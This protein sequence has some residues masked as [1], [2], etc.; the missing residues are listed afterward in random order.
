MKKLI[1]I[2]IT[3]CTVLILPP[4]SLSLAADFVTNPD[5]SLIY[6]NEN[7]EL[8][9]GF[10]K[11]KGYTYYFNRD[12]KMLTGAYFIG[13]AHYRFRDDGKMYIGWVKLA[14]GNY[15]YYLGDGKRAQG[16][17]KIGSATYYFRADG[18]M[19]RSSGYIIDNKIYTFGSDGKLIK[20]NGNYCLSGYFE[21]SFYELKSRKPSVINI[22]GEKTKSY[23]ADLIPVQYRLDSN[24]AIGMDLYIFVNDKLSGGL[25]SFSG[26]SKAVPSSVLSDDYGDL[27]KLAEE[28]IDVIFEMFYT[29]LEKKYGKERTDENTIAG[30]DNLFKDS[31]KIAVFSDKYTVAIVAVNDGVVSQL[32]LDKQ[33]ISTIN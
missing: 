16:F 7:G 26:T 24:Y 23:A 31:E 8:T 30:V 22:G 14:D 12:G 25:R 33:I 28:E 19:L 27:K 6:L 5:G 4:L 21:E 3:I 11:I 1:C 29:E 13:G 10:T 20:I 32:I 2:I 15:N 9:K 18:I 17:T